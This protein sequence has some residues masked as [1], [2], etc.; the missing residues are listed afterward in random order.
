M[1]RT[2]HEF[3]YNPSTSQCSL[4]AAY[5]P[6]RR[7]T[8]NDKIGY[9]GARRSHDRRRIQK[10]PDARYDQRVRGF[11]SS[12]RI[13]I[14]GRRYCAIEF[15]DDDGD[16]MEDY[17]DE[18]QMPGDE[19]LWSFCLGIFNTHTYTISQFIGSKILLKFIISALFMVTNAG[20]ISAADSSSTDF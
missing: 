15:T 17:T 3:V 13:I 10:Y 2:W 4:D 12:G 16:D 18:I 5:W 8:G 11:L 9:S 20:S 6:Q 7:S 19:E 1:N 14:R